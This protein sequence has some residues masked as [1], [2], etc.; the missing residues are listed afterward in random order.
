MSTPKPFNA[1]AL[2]INTRGVNKCS[3]RTAAQEVIDANLEHTEKLLTGSSRFIQVFGGDAVRLVV[4]PEYFLTSFPFGESI[5]AWKEKACLAPDGA[6]YERLGS[7]AQS[8]NI[9]LSGNVYETDDHFPDLYFQVSFIIAPNG[10]VICRYRRLIS[11]FAPT[12]HD[13]LD[14]YLDH[15]G[16]D[17][18]FPVAKTELGNMACVASEEILYPELSRALMLNGAEIICHSSSEVAS[19]LLSPKNIAKRARA[20]ENMA[21]VVSANSAALTDLDFP[22]DSTTGSSQIVDYKGALLAETLAGESSNANALIDIDRL[23]QARRKPAMTNLLARQRY[24]VVESSYQQ[25]IY[26]ANNLDNKL[27]D[28]E[29]F[30]KMQA[31]VIESLVK[32]GVIE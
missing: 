12:P 1:L 11:M 19:N 3:D 7:L 21:Y 13:V 14:A 22:A 4:L 26:P 29:H 18:L 30:M 9:Y 2:Q 6:E 17:S 10:N 27:P 16:K 23:R 8:L 15:Y 32:R 24:E 5:E 31:D 28:R 20:I 25:T